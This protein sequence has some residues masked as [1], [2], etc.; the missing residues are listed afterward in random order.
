MRKD[1]VEQ[2]RV[3][4]TY[5]PYEVTEQNILRV[6][7]SS[8]MLARQCLRKYWW[9]KVALPDIRI[10]PNE[11]MIKGTI[12]HKG[13]E[14]LYT[15]W[16]PENEYLGGEGDI[17]IIRGMLP[18]GTDYDDTFDEIAVMEE[19]RLDAWGPDFF[20]P[21]EAEVKHQVYDPEFDVMLVGMW[22][23]LMQHP[24]G[25]LCIMELQTGDLSTGKLSRVRRALCFYAR[26]IRLLGYEEKYGPVTHMMLISSDCIN[27]RTASTLLASKRKEVFM[28]DEKGITVI[29]RLGKRSHTAFEKDYARTVDGIRDMRWVPNW[30]DYFCA[31]YCEF[32][33]SCDE[34]LHGAGEDP[35]I[36]WNE[37]E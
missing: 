22:D 9:N 8:F 16:D 4:S 11:F 7:K 28:G 27:A 14:D 12:V 37:N 25:G 32:Y 26:M 5:N 3:D 15:D 33:L 20:Q 2:H 36:G 34:E 19:Q 21:V 6:S 35:T 10:P 24:D 31:N 30:S 29:E 1:A 23:G 13:V 18:V 17:H